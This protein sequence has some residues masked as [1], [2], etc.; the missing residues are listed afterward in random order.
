MTRRVAREAAIFATYVVLS[1][2]LTWPVAVRLDT[3]VSDLGDP[4]LVAWILDWTSWALVHQPL[5]LFDAPIFYPSVMPLAYSEHLAGIA[6]LMLPF[7]LAGASPVALHNLAMLLGFA[8][9]GYGAFV[10]AR[11]FVPALIPSFIAGIFYAFVSFKFDHLPHLQVVS[12]CWVPLT[13]AALVAFWRRPE[14]RRALLLAGALAMNGLTNVY[15]L[16]FTAAALGPT[17]VL[18]FFAGEKRHW[19]VW[20]RLVAALG[21]AL[22]VLLPFMLP[23]RTVSKIYNFQ[24][25]EEDVWRGACEWGDWLVATNRS[26]LYGG[27]RADYI[28]ERAV[29]PGLVA[30]LLAITGVVLIAPK[31]PAGG[32]T[33]DAPPRLLRALDVS[34]VFA[35]VVALLAAVSHPRFRLRMAG[36]TIVSIRDFDVPMLVLLLAILAR[37]SLRLPLA[38]GGA[39]GRTLRDA[40]RDSRFSIEAWVALLWTSI[41]VIGTLGPKTFYY[42]FLYDRIDAYQSIR[43]SGR[44]AVIAYVGMTVFVAMGAHALIERRRAGVR[45]H[46]TSALL[47]AL[48]LADVFPTVQW[49]QAVTTVPAVYRWIKRERVQP[50]VEWPVDNWLAFRYLLGSA[51]HRQQLMNGSSG[52]APPVYASMQHAWEKKRYAP[53]LD[54]AEKYGAAVLVFHAHWMDDME[55][56]A[57][58]AVIERGLE[59]GRLAYLRRFDHGVEGDFVFAV[60]RNLRDSARLRDPEVPDGSGRFPAQVLAE[61][62]RG[63]PASNNGPFGRM[64]SPGGDVRGPL[65]VSGW[66]ISPQ[67]IAEVRVLLDGGRYVYAATRSKRPDITSMYPWYY[68]YDSG[69]E[70]VIPRRPRGVPAKTD[71]QVEIVDGGG[72][73]TRLDDLLFTWE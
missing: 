14:W 17:L 1:I 6:L 8:L 24:R 18:L 62:L 65:R 63:R 26:L 41:G 52:F 58:R 43:S 51:H 22:V 7:Q 11:M 66:A 69:F 20:L 73:R 33:A 35:A 34:I 67:G 40:I 32:G 29:F 49:E 2:W 68:E 36:H 21:L 16:L 25:S 70:A 54:V 57:A 60:T 59:S 56:A 31:R 71:V 46:A 13:L 37:C 9:S 61:F 50:I 23:Y 3:A 72:Q 19:K 42:R 44:F 4:L 28:H 15:F 38:W 39:E 55:R 12:S 10:L 5:H 48:I 45:R 53:A 64:E 30:L 47:V 27:L